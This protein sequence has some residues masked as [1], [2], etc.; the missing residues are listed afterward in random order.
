MRLLSG[1]LDTPETG[2]VGPG[3]QFVVDTVLGQ[4][5]LDHGQAQLLRRVYPGL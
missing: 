2:E 1:Y 3:Q 5:L 4:D